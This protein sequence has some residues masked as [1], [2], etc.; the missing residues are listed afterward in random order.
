MFQAL[1]AQTLPF[2]AAAAEKT[3]DGKGGDAAF[4][5]F[6]PTYFSTQIFWLLLTF[7]VLYFVLSKVFLPQIGETLEERSSRIADDL[8]SASRMQ[9]QAE[10]AQKAYERALADAKAKAMN[11]AESTR[12]SIDAEVS[13]ELEAADADAAIQAEHAETRIRQIRGEALAKIDD[14]AAGVAQDTIKKITGKSVTIAKI[15]SAIGG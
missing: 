7:G 12:Q 4:P 3:A 1:F 15:K 14:I 11:V 2:A 13:A 6:D 9:R 8:D 5:P 10:E